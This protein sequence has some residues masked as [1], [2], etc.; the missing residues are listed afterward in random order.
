MIHEFYV[1]LW[2]P[3]KKFKKAEVG[4]RGLVK[5]CVNWEKSRLGRSGEQFVFRVYPSYN[6]K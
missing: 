1:C 5:R 3:L 4:E 6:G 2:S